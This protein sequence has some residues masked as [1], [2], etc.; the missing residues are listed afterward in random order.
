MNIF[1]HEIA[2]LKVSILKWALGISFL[3]LFWTAMYPSI[4]RDSENFKKIFNDFPPDVL[5][6]LGVMLDK[7]T[8]LNG[9]YSFIFSYVSLCGA[10][11]AMLWGLTVLS[12]ESSGKT[13]DFLLTKPA[14]RSVILTNKLLAVFFSIVLVDVIYYAVT[15]ACA[16][17]MNYDFDVK[18]FILINLSLLFIEIMFLAIGFIIGAVFKRIKAPVSVTLGIVVGFFVIGL[19]DRL[20]EDSGIK[21]ISLLTYFDPNSIISN[22]SYDTK[23]VIIS[24]ALSIILIIFSYIFFSKK[25]IHSA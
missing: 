20:F 25:D 15:S 14:K 2:A 3:A 23:Y 9:F 12:K 4:A 18:V 24:L 22:S 11:M 7:V 21:N 19:L 8:S 13:M 10:I 6:A 1:K 5:S 17:L 16:Y